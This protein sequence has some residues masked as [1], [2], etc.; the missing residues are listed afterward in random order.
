M[1]DWKYIFKK[2]SF[3]QVVWEDLAES[4]SLWTLT[5][6]NPVPRWARL[7]CTILGKLC[8]WMHIPIKSA[9]WDPLRVSGD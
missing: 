6:G 4:F 2:M 5:L 3:S 7:Q 1:T 8:L 9:K